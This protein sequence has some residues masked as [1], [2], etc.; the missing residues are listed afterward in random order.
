MGAVNGAEAR[1]VRHGFTLIEMMIVV[2]IMSIV[3]AI[4]AV[5]IDYSKLRADASGRL[6]RTALSR[7]QRLAVLRQYDVIV[8]VDVPTARIRLVEDA[9]DNATADAGERVTWMP[10]ENGAQIVAPLSRVGGGGSV[11][12]VSGSALR[13]I[14]GLPS[15][16]YHRDGSVS[17]SLELYLATGLKKP[18]DYRGLLVVAATGRVDWYRYTASGWRN[19][20]T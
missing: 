13:T 4:V 20:G 10:L 18:D 3:T 5:R 1:R 12:A 16:I 8:S 15:V 6:V 17:S 11:G 2:T 19:G 14:D 9:N 7:A